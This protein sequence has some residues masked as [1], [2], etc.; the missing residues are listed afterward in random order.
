[1]MPKTRLLA[2]AALMS[3][4]LLAA[5][6]RAP[7]ESEEHKDDAMA[8][9]DM[10]AEKKDAP[11]KIPMSVTLTPA[12]VEQ[13]RVKWDTVSIGTSAGAATVPGEVIANEDATARLGAPV[14]G[15]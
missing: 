15:A 9:M 2:T 8:G 5:C 10:G 4:A 11:G 12:Q 6:N 7:D 3:A 13:G 1:M 14:R